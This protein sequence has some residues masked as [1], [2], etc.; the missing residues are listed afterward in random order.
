MATKKTTKPKSEEKASTASVSV[1][2]ESTSIAAPVHIRVEG[3]EGPI[4]AAYLNMPGIHQT[5]E[6]DHT[7]YVLA[8]F[9]YHGEVEI[10]AK[11][12]SGRGRV[13]T[14]LIVR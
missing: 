2:P 8:A 5:L 13:S 7:G 6:P 10:S 3:T 14:T 12:A 11:R 9:Q 4:K 1:E